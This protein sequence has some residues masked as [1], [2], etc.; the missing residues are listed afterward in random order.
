M[1][2]KNVVG[3]TCGLK[4]SKGKCHLELGG[5]AFYRKRLGLW[6]PPWEAGR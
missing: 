5:P 3:T 1:M 2:E 6:E 4:E